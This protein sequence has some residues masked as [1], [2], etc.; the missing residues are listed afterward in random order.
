MRI[1]EPG[2]YE[3]DADLYHA[4]PCAEP[5]LS[6][7]MIADVLT[8]PRKAWENSRRLNPDWEEPEGAER[9]TIGT[10]SHVMFLEP[11]QFERKV[12]VLD[13]PDFRSKGAKD[14]RA[15]AKAHGYTA[16]LAHH[17]EKVKRARKRFLKDPEMFR[18]FQGGFFERSMFWK[19]PIHGF[20][21]RSR[22][23]FT[24][25]DGGHLSDYKA[26]A[27]ADPTQFGRHAF[28]M[29]YHRRAAWYLE[30]AEIVL[31]KR[32]DKY[33]FANQ[34]VKA[35]FLTSAVELGISAL[36]AGQKENDRAAAIFAKCLAR[37]EWP[38]YRHPDMPDADAS[39]TVEMPNYAMMQIDERTPD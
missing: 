22:P 37:D 19:H 38:G 34:E 2:V 29:S 7:G 21:C 36:E 3:M 15:S 35:P 16:I 8:A 30:G 13:F 9:F 17:F 28:Q 10:V 5:S 4:D 39:F 6:A 1:T 23:D 31:G 32:P 12:M 24:A 27:N 18:K 33:W 14:A 25:S 11:E 26:T 20:W